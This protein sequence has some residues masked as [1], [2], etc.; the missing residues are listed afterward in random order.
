MNAPNLHGPQKK[1]AQEVLGIGSHPL[2]FA[3]CRKSVQTLRI[4]KELGVFAGKCLNR[5]GGLGSR[6]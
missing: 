4:G 3:G 5:R 1:N 6:S 2:G